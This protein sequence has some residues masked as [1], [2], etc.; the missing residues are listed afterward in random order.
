MSEIKRVRYF[1]G[2]FLVED[3][4]IAEQDYHRNMRYRH[5][6]DFHTWGIVTGLEATFTAG[7]TIVTI[8]PGL[9]VDSEGK[10]IVLTGVRTLDFNTSGFEG[11]KSYYITIAW[12]QQ[13]SDPNETGEDKRWLEIPIIDTLAAAPPKSEKTLILGR[14]SLD[15]LKNIS[16]IDKS[17][18]TYSAINI[19]DDSVTSPKIKEADGISGQYTGSGSG[20]K[21]GHIQDGAVTAPKLDLNLTNM[22]NNTM[23]T[24]S[25][26]SNIEKKSTPHRRQ[27]N[28]SSASTAFENHSQVNASSNSMANGNRSQVNASD[29]ATAYGKYSQ[30]NA[31][32]N[33]LASGYSS[34]VNASDN[35][36]AIGQLSQVNASYSS[37]ANG[38]VSQVN[39][40]YFSEA[41]GQISQVNAS[42]TSIAS[43]RSS[44]VNASGG[45]KANGEHSQVNASTFSMASK[46]NSQV[47][48][49]VLTE[50]PIPYS[51]CG[52]F[53][54][55]GEPNS[56]NRKWLINSK[57]G[58]V[59]I[60]G[61]LESGTPFKDYGE[62]FENLKKDEIDIGLLIALEGAKVRPAKKDEDFIGVVSGTAA[63]RLG[64]SPFCWKGRYMND[65]WGRPVYE[66][67]KDPG[68]EP[69]K[70]PDEKWSPQKGETEE[71]RPTIRVQK[72][73]PDYDPQREQVP[74]S[75]RPKEW[76]LV[77]LLGQVYVRCD[78]S[79]KPGD[80][81]KS[82][83]KG[84]G[85][86][87]DEKTKLRAM[88]VTQEFD[89]KYSIVLCLLN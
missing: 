45:S 4:F 23:G 81:V 62:Y 79:V 88:T 80:F 41:S 28:A 27:V 51:I 68:W 12:N 10:E 47:N 69:K 75:E 8:S 39:A 52:G 53:G 14:V 30:V 48:A 89:G 42:A 83:S 65:E 24:I 29:N 50:N 76:T 78:G 66:E 5:N 77:G 61:K 34:Q 56:A 84:I 20:V 67:I 36:K 70:V 49:S 54:D 26:D 18:C 9:A 64:D 71:D 13:G 57:D 59:Q 37:T 17:E 44:Q 72:E 55:K 2:E 22:L 15:A 16:S 1:D 33:S 7:G 46:E 6:K 43:G 38:A 32:T 87:S 85:T 73:N 58:N 19:G 63:V 21:T 31:S 3:D 82:G 35:S 86:K 40:G 60:A 11:E 74:R 25:S